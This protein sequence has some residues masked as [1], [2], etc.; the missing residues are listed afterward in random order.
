MNLKISLSLLLFLQLTSSSIFAQGDGDLQKQMEACSKIQCSDLK[1][2]N[3][4][5]CDKSKGLCFRNAFK[6][7][8]AIWKELGIKKDEKNKV[9][10]SLKKTLNKNEE[11]HKS[12]LKEADYISKIIEEVKKLQKEVGSLKP[13]K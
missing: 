4:M 11:L 12:I 6:K 5:E 3:K 10:A 7:R 13:T 2:K 9:M 8:V 1:G